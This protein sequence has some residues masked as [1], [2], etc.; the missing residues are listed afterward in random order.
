MKKT[1]NMC[2]GE[3]A[4]DTKSRFRTLADYE[5]YPQCWYMST[6]CELG[7]E[8]ASER[9]ER[10]GI[11]NHT[12]LDS[13]C[14]GSKNHGCRHR[15][16][17]RAPR[18]D[19]HRT[20]ALTAVYETPPPV[21]FVRSWP[22]GARDLTDFNYFYVRHRDTSGP[23]CWNDFRSFLGDVPFLL[24]QSGGELANSSRVGWTIFCQFSMERVDLYGNRK[25]SVG[26]RKIAPMTPSRWEPWAPSWVAVRTTWPLHLLRE[27]VRVGR[28]PVNRV[29]RH[30]TETCV[31]PPP[32]EQG[33][34]LSG[35]ATTSVTYA[36]PVAQDFLSRFL[37]NLSDDTLRSRGVSPVRRVEVT[38]ST[39]G[40]DV[41]DIRTKEKRG[42][43]R[44]LF[45]DPFVVQ[46]VLDTPESTNVT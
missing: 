18:Q 11:S 19:S 16:R 26:S 25:R 9:M 28:G 29:N 27:P 43:Y 13:I 7:F 21:T 46:W 14:F 12:V 35:E 22:E 40:T 41:C 1:E 38:R 5:V 39:L 4:N 42:W 6:H 10:K 20:W 2:L 30:A 15:G 45:P 24:G 32:S 34:S 23:L 17:Q 3:N 33:T 44:G 36:G 31:R 8:G 37:P